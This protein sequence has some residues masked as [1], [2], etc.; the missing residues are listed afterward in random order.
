MRPEMGRKRHAGGRADGRRV[1]R[2]ARATCE[3][4]AQEVEE[5]QARRPDGVHDSRTELRR[6]RADLDLMGHTVFDAEATAQ[7]CRRMHQL[8]QALAKTRDTDVLIGDLDGYLRRRAKERA[9]LGELR[10]LLAKRRHKGE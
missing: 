7:I 3:Q 5:S 8:E 10:T 6:L 9:G 4:V 2:R 1:A